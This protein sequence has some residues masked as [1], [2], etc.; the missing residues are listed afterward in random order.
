MLRL[1][2]RSDLSIRVSGVPP[3]VALHAGTRQTGLGTGGSI[4]YSLQTGHVV[5]RLS[6][7]VV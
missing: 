1:Q 6:G 3:P 2:I 7:V 5:L 4:R